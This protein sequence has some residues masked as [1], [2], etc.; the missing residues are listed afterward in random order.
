D[1]AGI[2]I[3]VLLFAE[4]GELT[5][6]AAV[7]HRILARAGVPITVLA[8]SSFDE[9]QLKIELATAD[10]VVDALF[11]SGLQGAVRPPFDRVIMGINAARARVFAVD[12]PSGLDSDTGE[13]MGATVRADHTASVAALKRGFLQ[14]AAR[15]W[16]GKV[17][18]IDM[19]APRG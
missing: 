5:G 2:Q 3:C 9:T 1:N 7:N 15:P 14:P 16:V 19:G 12:I 18:L 13:P 11:G 6:D 17:H 10:W 4:P 8:G